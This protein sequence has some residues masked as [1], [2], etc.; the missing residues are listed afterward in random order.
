[1]HKVP[2]SSQFGPLGSHAPRQFPAHGRKH[3]PAGRRIAPHRLGIPFPILPSAHRATNR[4]AQT[5]RYGV[6]QSPRVN[7]PLG[8]REAANGACVLQ[9]AN[10]HR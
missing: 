3:N 5:I 4:P 2:L 8:A 10:R 7:E 6:N 1:M 9:H